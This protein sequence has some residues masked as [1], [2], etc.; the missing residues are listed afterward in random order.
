MRTEKYGVVEIARAR[1]QVLKE[2]REIAG[3]AIEIDEMASLPTVRVLGG[4][5]E[6][7]VNA[8][9]SAEHEAGC[10]ILNDPATTFAHHLQLEL[11]R[12]AVGEPRVLRPAVGHEEE[13]H[14]AP[15]FQ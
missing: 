3:T 8:I 10:E 2:Q 4:L 14:V 5:G 7:R 12:I 15:L 1:R 6:Q 11:A 9:G 13:L